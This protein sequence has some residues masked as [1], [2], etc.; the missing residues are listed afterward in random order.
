MSPATAPPAS[1]HPAASTTPMVGTVAHGGGA[2]PNPVG[3]M[4]EYGQVTDHEVHDLPDFIGC[5]RSYSVSES[6]SGS[7]KTPRI[8]SSNS[9]GVCVYRFRVVDVLSWPMTARTMFT[10]TLS[11]TS[12]VAYEC[13]RSWN[14][15][16]PAA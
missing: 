12:H 4:Q 8:R 5:V 11:E 10:G 1:P 3:A 15:S 2:D 16:P 13:L 7:S 6:L 9:L 14:L